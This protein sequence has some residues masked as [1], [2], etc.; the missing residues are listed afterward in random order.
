MTA[1]QAPRPK[2][3]RILGQVMPVN[4]YLVEAP[5]GVVIVDGMLTVTDAGRV[6]HELDRL[7][8]P[9]LGAIVTHAHPDH[10]AGMA[11]ILRGR[12]V[13][14]YATAPVRQT[15]ERDD[16]IKD[17]IVGP[18]MQQEWPAR[19]IFPNVDVTAG[20]TLRL[21]SLSFE[22][23]DLGPAE[24]PADSLYILSDQAWFVGDLVYSQM[25]AYLA[26]G[27][28]REWLVCLDRLERDLGPSTVLYPG[29][30][31]PGGGGLIQAQRRYVRAFVES[32]DRHLSGAPAERRAKVVADM[33]QLL[34]TEDLAFLMELSVDAFAATRG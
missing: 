30:G 26:D 18:M 2:V 8:K 32:V 15:I 24:S 10:Y 16:A 9:V 4:C 29:H 5:D 1:T 20:S 21:G 3:H 12:R 11:E 19:R 34:P 28:A 31:L 25:H 33:K 23:L 14:V 13:P 7:D 27:F 22:V 17:R 6:R